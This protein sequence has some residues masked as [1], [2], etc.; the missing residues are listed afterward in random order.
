M[1]ATTTVLDCGHNPTPDSGKMS[2][3]NDTG[4]F[5]AI[6]REMGIAVV[7]IGNTRHPLLKNERFP[8]HHDQQIFATERG[9]NG[10]PAV[11]K[12]AQRAGIDEG[13]GNTGQRRAD[14][15]GLERGVWVA[16]IDGTWG[17]IA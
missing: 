10:W 13:C 1:S 3:K 4:A 9:E 5:L 8:H 14:T 6:A 15:S 11:W 7:G 2:A 16:L 12:L 17:R